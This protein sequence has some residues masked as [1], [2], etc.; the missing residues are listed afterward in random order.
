MRTV[1]VVD[2][3]VVVSVVSVATAVVTVATVRPPL[4]SAA[5]AARPWSVA[6]VAIAAAAKV[7][8]PVAIAPAKA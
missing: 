8:V 2:R 5:L 3:A 1:H 7:A 4:L 6:R